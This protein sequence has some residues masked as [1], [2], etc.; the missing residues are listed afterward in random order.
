MMTRRAGLVSMVAYFYQMIKIHKTPWKTRPVISAPGC[1]TEGLAKW[2]HQELHPLSSALDSCLKSSLELKLELDRFRPPADRMI[3]LFTADAKSMYTNIDTDHALIVFAAYFRTHPNP[4]ATAILQALDIIMKNNV[5]K[6]DDLFYLQCNGT[7]M[8]TPPAP[9]YANLYFGAHE[10]RRLP[11]WTA[12]LALYK[13]YIDDI[14][15]IWICDPNAAED[16][17][18]WLEFQQQWNSFGQL[19]WEFSEH[20]TTINYLDLTISLDPHQQIS[21]KLFEKPQNIYAYLSPLSCHPPG[22]IKGLIFGEVNRICKLT[23]KRSDRELSISKLY[24]RVI[25]RGHNHHTIRKLI[26]TAIQK[27]HQRRTPPPTHDLWNVDRPVCLHLQYHP[28]NITRRSIQHL[29]QTT[30]LQPPG[31]PP[32]PDLLN[33]PNPLQQSEILTNRLIVCNHRSHNLKNI[34]FPRKF[35]KVIDRNASTYLPQL[36]APPSNDDGALTGT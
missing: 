30:M 25:Q 23:S 28:A 12:S 33:G 5:F 22:M 17:R 15:G 35:R 10:H 31:E 16:Q 20:T 32:L 14:F 29:F 1:L 4:N 13:R 3:R 9:A 6:F 24:H 18:K 2:L 19:E 34:L 8:G 7:A 21:T 36:H 27:Q 26:I 11:E